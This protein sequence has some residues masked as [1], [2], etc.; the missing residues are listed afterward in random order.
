MDRNRGSSS[1]DSDRDFHAGYISVE[2]SQE[3]RFT[4]RMINARL[5]TVSDGSRR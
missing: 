1:F 5:V 4:P 2:V 3:T